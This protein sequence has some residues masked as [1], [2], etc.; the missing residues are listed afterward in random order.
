MTARLQNKKIGF[1][2]LQ[3]SVSVRVS[4]E[5]KEMRVFAIALALTSAS[6]NFVAHLLVSLSLFFCTPNGQKLQPVE[7]H[8]DF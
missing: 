3:I 4:L 1:G 2:K 5:E 7:R 8:V 6:R